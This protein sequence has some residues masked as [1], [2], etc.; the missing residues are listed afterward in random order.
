MLTKLR[1][2]NVDGLE[3]DEAVALYAFGK[4]LGQTYAEFGL[5]PP[6]WVGEQLEV[7]RREIKDRQR[8]ALIKDLKDTKARREGLR[9]VDEK[10]AELDAKIARLEAAIGG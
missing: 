4:T 8:D 9:T 3:V 7:L 1:T 6:E 10:R 2:F 5:E